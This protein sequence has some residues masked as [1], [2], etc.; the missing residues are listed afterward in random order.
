MENPMKQ[1]ECT[2][3]MLCRECIPEIMKLCEKHEDPHPRECRFI[4]YYYQMARK[5]LPPGYQVFVKF[6]ELYCRFFLAKSRIV[7]EECTHPK[8][9]IGLILLRKMNP[10]WFDE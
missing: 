6:D 4:Q 3:P 7:V 8:A 1:Q 9:L 5:E 2:I 10:E